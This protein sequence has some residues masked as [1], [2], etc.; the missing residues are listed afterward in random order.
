M[1]ITS[2][3][4][5][6]AI[7]SADFNSLEGW[8]NTKVKVK[9]PTMR[10]IFLSI[11]TIS[12]SNQA[13]TP[14]TSPASITDFIKWG[15]TTNKHSP[16]EAL[17][18]PKHSR[19]CI[20]LRLATQ[21]QLENIYHTYYIL[22][23]NG[24]STLTELRMQYGNCL[25]EIKENQIIKEIDLLCH[26][27][28]STGH[29]TAPQQLTQYLRRTGTTQAEM[30]ERINAAIGYEITANYNLGVRANY[31]RP[32]MPGMPGMP[33]NAAGGRRTR[34]RRRRTTRRR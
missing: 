14:R 6:D 20:S 22:V 1:E 32:G 18:L 27:N 9:F 26:L 28:R 4:F 23:N 16:V 7:R 3:Q 21:Q 15:T 29:Q 31:G 12:S 8:I 5:F 11:F 17:F 2:G 30:K 13:Q 10:N 33:G 24:A 34:R 19:E 25:D